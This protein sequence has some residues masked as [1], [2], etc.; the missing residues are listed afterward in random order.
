VLPAGDLGINKLVKALTDK[1]AVGLVGGNPQ[2]LPAETLIETGVKNMFHAREKFKNY[3]RRGHN[4][5]G[6]WGCV[7]AMSREFVKT[8]TLPGDVPDDAFS[9]FSCIS[10]GFSFRHV[11]DAVVYFRSPQTIADQVAQGVRFS[12]AAGSLS[13][14]FDPD[15]IVQEYFVPLSWKAVSLLEQVWRNPLAYLLLKYSYFLVV[16]A[17]EKKHSPTWLPVASTKQLIAGGRC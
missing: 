9:Y 2:P 13:D 14:Y 17:K 3:S 6:L 16:R 1:K 5:Y 4:V 12:T 11:R 7:M 10:N 8:L 15:L